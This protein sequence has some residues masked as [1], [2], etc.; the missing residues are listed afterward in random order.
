MCRYSHPVI[1]SGEVEGF[2]AADALDKAMPCN[3]APAIIVTPARAA[4]LRRS[5]LRFAN[6][7]S[8]QFL[9]PSF[10]FLVFH[11]LIIVIP[12]NLKQ[13]DACHSILLNLILIKIARTPF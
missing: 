5:I 10:L 1:E 13:K 2:S 6:F 12:G 8:I 3:E 7:F 9:L 11:S 4:A